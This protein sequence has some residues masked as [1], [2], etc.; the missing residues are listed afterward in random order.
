MNDAALSSFSYLLK[1]MDK[2]SGGVIISDGSA[3]GSV[4]ELG[5]PTSLLPLLETPAQEL[6]V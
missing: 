6:A 3:V 4:S 2:G 1:N 5:S